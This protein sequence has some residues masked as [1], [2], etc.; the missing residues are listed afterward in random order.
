MREHDVL[1]WNKSSLSL[2]FPRSLALWSLVPALLALAPLAVVRTDTARLLLRGT[3]HCVGLSEPPPLARA[4]ASH[5]PNRKQSRLLPTLR[6]RPPAPLRPASAAASAG[7]AP[8][9]EQ[10]SEET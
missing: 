8:R 4:A 9:Y 10:A 2:W 1:L 5:G 7:A 6:V 3:S